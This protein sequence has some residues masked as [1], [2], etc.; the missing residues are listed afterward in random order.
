MYELNNLVTITCK[1]NTHICIWF[2]NMQFLP[3]TI[4]MLD[5]MKAVMFL[6]LTGLF[7]HVHWGIFTMISAL[8]NL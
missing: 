6:A 2:G 7:Y 3:N 5:V 1:V 8:Q 4:F